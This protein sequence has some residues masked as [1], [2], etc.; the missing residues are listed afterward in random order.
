MTYCFSMNCA[1]IFYLIYSDGYIKCQ[2][3]KH[4]FVNS[5]NQN[6][7]FPLPLRTD[8]WSVYFKIININGQN[9]KLYILF[10]IK[11]RKTCFNIFVIIQ[12]TLCHDLNIYIKW[13]EYVVS[14]NKLLILDLYI[15]V[16]LL[17][18]NI[19]FLIFFVLY[20]YIYIYIYIY[21]SF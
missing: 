17:V 9:L 3:E 13:F 18:F 14:F 1:N 16:E 15:F 11:R 12:N 8:Y 6:S 21:C 20:I 5:F 10:V 7:F 4:L 2:C 19:T